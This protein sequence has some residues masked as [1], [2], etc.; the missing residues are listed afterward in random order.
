MSDARGFAEI[1]S[2]R[3]PGLDDRPDPSRGI[4]GISVAAELVGSAP[5]N[6][7]LY[8]TRGLI[9]PARSQGGTRRY[10]DDDLIRLRQIGRLLDDGLNLAGIA[11]VL[12]LQAANQ[13][14]R[15][16]LDDTRRRAS[17]SRSHRK[18]Q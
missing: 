4:Y 6:L 11:A 10:S 3:S 13:A 16:E 12:A 5:Q 14:L 9:N 2:S 8:E 18:R 7:R 1:P 15:V 17:E